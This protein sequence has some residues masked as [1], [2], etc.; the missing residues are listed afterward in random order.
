MIDL[1]RRQFLKAAS[2]LL[3]SSCAGPLWAA[4]TSTRPT[5]ADK[6][7]FEPLALFLTWQRDPTTT[8]TVQWIGGE[9]DGAAAADLVCQSRFGRLAPSG[10]RRATLSDVGPKD[11][12]HRARGPGARKRISLSRRARFGRARF[13][14]HA[15]QGHGCVF[16]RLRW[17][18]RHRAPGSADQSRGRRARSDVHGA[19]R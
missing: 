7:T 2:G 18:Q 11:L 4:E 19:G 5:F 1:R 17:R 12:S 3:V 13:S 10:R 6:P 14:H 16:V 9:A 15:G 8:M